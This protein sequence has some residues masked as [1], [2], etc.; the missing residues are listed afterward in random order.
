MALAS[1]NPSPMIVIITPG[2][3]ITALSQLL[4]GNCVLKT[5]LTKVCVSVKAKSNNI[6]DNNSYNA[7]LQCT[8]PGQVDIS[9]MTQEWVIPRTV[10][11]VNTEWSFD[12][13]AMVLLLDKYIIVT[14]VVDWTSRLQI[15]TTRDPC[16]FYI[17]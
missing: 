17:M 4:F 9:Q 7:T 11:L 1:N 5:L 15:M 10:Y 6:A 14:K 2:A 3:I 8:I 13:T 12:K 16:E